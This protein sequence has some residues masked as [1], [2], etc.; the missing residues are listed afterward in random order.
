MEEFEGKAVEST[1]EVLQ[2]K[3]S[4]SRQL[5]YALGA[6]IVI[7]VLLRMLLLVFTDA[8][9]IDDT[10][11][12]IKLEPA[13]VQPTPQIDPD[14]AAASAYADNF[15]FLINFGLAFSER[16]NNEIAIKLTEE[17]LKIRPDDATAL[18]NLGFYMFI[19]G[20]LE[21][22]LKYLKQS[23]ANYPNFEHV[24]NNLLHTYNALYEAADSQERKDEIQREIEALQAMQANQA[25][26][27]PAPQPQQEQVP[28]AQPASQEQPETQEQPKGP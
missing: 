23:F 10:A 21:E 8:P 22:S 9:V 26:P 27:T 12:A 13:A 14:Q 25:A 15:D 3:L 11:P 28:A 17:A 1:A 24:Y 18:N 16:H 5:N 7:Y 4:Q 6:V 19:D 20:K 2:Q